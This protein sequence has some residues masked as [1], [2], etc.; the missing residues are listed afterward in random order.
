MLCCPGD[1][2]SA[3]AAAGSAAAA[4]VQPSCKLVYHRAVHHRALH[5]RPAVMRTAPQ[6]AY[7]VQSH[8]YRRGSHWVQGQAS[9]VQHTHVAGHVL[10][11]LSRCFRHKGL[12]VPSCRKPSM[13]L[14]IRSVFYSRQRCKRSCI[15]KWR[16]RR[17]CSSRRCLSGRQRR[18]WS[19][20][21]RCCQYWHASC[22]QRT[23]P[24]LCLLVESRVA[25]PSVE[26]QCLLVGMLRYVKNHQTL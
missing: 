19:R 8:A 9:L 7:R 24:L 1:S 11:V 14:M 18:C 6:S 10:L 13:L 3:A 25:L 23:S 5:E 2:A 17:Q 26:I 22:S 4:G 15:S 21:R 12:A 20:Q 16:V